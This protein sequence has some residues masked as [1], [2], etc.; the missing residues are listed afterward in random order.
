MKRPTNR[1]PYEDVERQLLKIFKG[2]LFDP[3]LH[4][5]KKDAPSVEMKVENAD[6][7]PLRSAL[8]TGK[9]QFQDGVFSGAFTSA[10]S[11]TLRSIGAK[12]D[13][14]SNV[15][16]LDTSLVPEWVRAESGAFKEKARDIHKALSKRL[17]EIEKGLDDS[18][19][20]YTVDAGRTVDIVDSG[21]KGVAR[22]LEILPSIGD[23]AK[24][25]LSKDY[26]E[27]MKLW[28]KKFS[29]E[30]I[31]E[32]RG[33]VEQNALTGYRFAALK[34]GI[35]QRYGV[36][37]SKSNFLARQETGLFMSKFRRERYGEAG[38]K[39]YRW[40]TSH[41]ERVRDRHKHLDGKVFS[42]SAPPIVDAAT[43]RRANP[44]EDFNCRCVDIPLVAKS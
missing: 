22:G 35:Q 2:I 39:Q 42:Y 20:L 19:N 10:T 40:S 23:D 28:I 43:G 6:D 11:K 16:R 34:A 1:I 41:D 33:I 13:K 9:I 26:T 32:L 5:I 15:F 17:D 38:I 18:V 31:R 25:R 3:L 8:K 27:N 29:E 7:L 44:G 36:T 21:F 24:D 14:R 37:V 30:Q 12:F 4:T